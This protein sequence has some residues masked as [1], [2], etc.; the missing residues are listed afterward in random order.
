MFETV[1][2]L[3]PNDGVPLLLSPKTQ[4]NSRSLSNSCYRAAALPLSSDVY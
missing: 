2:S 4:V 1:V 3:M